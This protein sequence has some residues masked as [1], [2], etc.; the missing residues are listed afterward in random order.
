[1]LEEMDEATAGAVERIGMWW[2]SQGLP[3]IAGRILGFLVLQPEAVALDDIALAIKV[4]KASVSTDARL[5]DRMG[6]VNRV[7][8]P[9][10]R[11]DYYE[12]QLD[13][14]RRIIIERLTALESFRDTL[15]A[16]AALSSTSPVVQQRLT[17][18]SRCQ[19]KIICSLRGLLST[20]SDEDISPLP[21]NTD[22]NHV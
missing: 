5:L 16:A 15:V 3:R 2:E 7:S 22:I 17:G 1:M 9:G 20:L 8:K 11:R 4:S 12:I 19:E 14:P 13:M 21:R 18:F 6:L 10:D